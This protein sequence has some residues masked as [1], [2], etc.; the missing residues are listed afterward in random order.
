MSA[1]LRAAEETT[2]QK[3]SL[4]DR[5]LRRTIDR[6]QFQV[7]VDGITAEFATKYR[8]LGQNHLDEQLKTVAGQLTAEVANYSPSRTIHLSQNPGAVKSPPSLVGVH[9][10][11]RG[12]RHR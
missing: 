12:H 6:E 3:D 10:V 8:V 11:D 5:L 7:A 2:E 4:I 1:D 9:V